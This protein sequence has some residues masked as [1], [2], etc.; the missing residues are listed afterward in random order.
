MKTYEEF[1]KE[2]Q[3]KYLK[4]ELY[5]GV[6]IHGILFITY[7]LEYTYGFSNIKEIIK[8]ILGLLFFKKKINSIKSLN[9]NKYEFLIL[10]NS[11][12]KEI[13]RKSYIL[14]NIL[15]K[16]NKDKVLL[17][18]FN[19]ELF[20]KYSIK[21]YDI[22]FTQLP[23]LTTNLKMI[24]YINFKYLA[25]ISKYLK[26]IDFYDELLKNIKVKAVITT[27]DNE[28]LDYI[29]TQLAK[30]NN[31]K[32]ISHQHGIFLERVGYEYY[33]SDYILVWG[34]KSKEF[35]EKK[36]VLKNKKCYIVGTS[37]FNFL[38][39]Y[40]NSEKK[41][42]V[43]CM[44]DDGKL[45]NKKELI[46][47]F[48][49][50]DINFGKKIIKLHPYQNMENFKKEYS[51]L[52]K[53]I[54]ITKNYNILKNAKYLITFKTTALLD[55]IFMGASILDIVD[56][57]P[58]IKYEVKAEKMEEEI[59]KRENNINY[60]NEIFKIQETELLKNIEYKNS[61]KNELKVL[62]DI[63]KETL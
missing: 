32:T 42:V 49:D 60:F 9:K 36:G 25:A 15:K 44:T 59:L 11:D 37:K 48:N 33:Y 27:Q 41:D 14:E 34:E 24:K 57:S 62:K 7:I 8:V 50:I 55:G 1:C 31:I 35:L 40:R 30:K 54:I 3:S 63:I 58:K 39:K 56:E 43:L 52:N 2:F 51:F 10:L 5:K 19:K 17:I 22:V 13:N 29:F 38:L 4:N 47:Y 18:S 53:S 61:E 23:K 16:I 26:I 46:K 12:T 20:E 28:P 21:G 6:N 45:S